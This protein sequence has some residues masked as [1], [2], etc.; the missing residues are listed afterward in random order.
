MTLLEFYNKEY[1]QKTREDTALLAKRTLL[2]L[3]YFE[4]GDNIF[5][6]RQLNYLLE[7]IL[8]GYRHECYKVVTSRGLNRLNIFPKGTLS[9]QVLPM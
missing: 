3:R 6:T 5:D 4:V 2:Y 8:Y 7:N 1:H 9:I